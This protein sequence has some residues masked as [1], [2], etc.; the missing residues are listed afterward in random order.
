MATK[1]EVQKRRIT[2]TPSGQL[3]ATLVLSF[4]AIVCLLPLLWMVLIALRPAGKSLAT[5]V[6]FQP[7][8]FTL[9][10]FSRV[11]EIIP[12]GSNFYNSAFTT[13]IG[14]LFTLFFCSL[15]G[16]AFAKF[17]FP[18]K[19]ALFFI[20]IITLLIPAEVGIVPLFGIMKDLNLINNLWALIIP[21][22]ATA[23]GIFYMTQYI[24]GVPDEVIEAA[25]VDGCSYFRI[26]YMIV[27]PMIKPAL[28]VW[29]VVTVVARWNDFFWPLVFLR[30]EEQYTLMLSLSF[31]P[32]GEG[33]STPWPV[34]MA[35]A[36][37]AV[38][39]I[40]ILYVL[41]QRF[42][43]ENLTSGAVKG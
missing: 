17:N 6:L 10:N 26:Y 5:S 16:F 8:E 22:A 43:K 42:Q 4:I 41:F 13:I 38:I 11:A 39:P 21:K 25:R 19:K 32:V 27:L 31:L 35:G 29:A 18:L 30:S 7:S 1:K 15:A 36:T 24:Q 9:S 33:L 14:T 23:I 40:I 20:V 2:R 3:V 34:I 28:G 12:L 37:I